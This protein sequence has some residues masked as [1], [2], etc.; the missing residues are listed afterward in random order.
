MVENG[1]GWRLLKEWSLIL[2]IRIINK[3]FKPGIMGE[4]GRIRE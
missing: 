2:Y 4:R 1:L 3:K